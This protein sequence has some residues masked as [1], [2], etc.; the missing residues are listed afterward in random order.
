MLM[1]HL[2]NNTILQLGS[3]HIQICIGFGKSNNIGSFFN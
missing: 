1:E 3:Q 2:L